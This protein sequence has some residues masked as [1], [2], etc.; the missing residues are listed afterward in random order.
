M[1]SNCVQC[2]NVLFLTWSPHITEPVDPISPDNIK[3]K[4]KKTRNHNINTREVRLL[5]YSNYLKF[6]PGMWKGLKNPVR[7]H[8]ENEWILVN[9]LEVRKTRCH[10]RKAHG[11]IKPFP[12]TSFTISEP[13]VDKFYVVQERSKKKELVWF[14]WLQDV[15]LGTLKLLQIDSHGFE[16]FTYV[17][18]KSSRVGPENRY[19]ALLATFCSYFHIDARRIPLKHVSFSSCD[20]Y[21]NFQITRP[22]IAALSSF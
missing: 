18:W 5:H 11:T 15:H 6:T 1:C 16:I 17:Y 14:L 4:R 12:T 3:K 10:S 20:L 8:R 21:H 2:Q 9:R 13:W 19:F 7:A 22:R